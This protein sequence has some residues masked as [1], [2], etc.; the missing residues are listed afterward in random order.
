MRRAK[1]L[2]ISGL[3]AVAVGVVPVMAAEP[4]HGNPPE[5]AAV[6]QERLVPIA[7]C[8]LLDTRTEPA[9]TSAEEVSRTLKMSEAHCSQIIPKYAAGYA[10]RVITLRRGGPEEGPLEV[11]V[12]PSARIARQVSDLLQFP[13]PAGSHLAVDIEGY[14]VPPGI[15]IDAADGAATS[16]VGVT[17]Q[18]VLQPKP[19]DISADKSKGDLFLD[20]SPPFTATG[21]RLEGH[22][23]NPY[24]VLRP[25]SNGAVSF[26]KSGAPAV[27][28]MNFTDGGAMLLADNTFMGGR[29][30][31]GGQTDKRVP[32]NKVH[33]ITLVDPLDQNGS[34]TNRVVLYN[35]NITEENIA[36]GTTTPGPPTTK[37]Q[38]FTLGNYSSQANINFD[39]QV[40]YH[41]GQY[42]YRA[43]SDVESKETFWVKASPSA[44]GSTYSG[45]RATMYVSGPAGFGT[46]NAP[47]DAI[48]VRAPSPGVRVEEDSQPGSVALLGDNNVDGPYL[49]SHTGTDG[50]ATIG[51]SAHRIRFGAGVLVMED[52][53]AVSAGTQRTF[54]PRLQLDSGGRVVIGNPTVDPNA[55]LNVEGN[56]TISGNINAKYQDL[57]EWV[58]A[59]EPMPVGTVVVIDSTAVNGVAPSGRAYDTAVAGVISAQP[60][61]IL[62]TEAASK[63]KV[64]TT[65]R[66]KVRVSA[67]NG[68]IHA[69]DLLV[70]SGRPGTAMRSEPIDV[71]GVEIHRPGTLIGKALEPLS[72]GEGEILVLLS[73]Q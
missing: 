7:P 28:L 45:T 26:Y 6:A 67:S 57:A 29:Y 59:S 17:G 40:H 22:D 2:A 3:V 10:V 58:A 66:V 60:G 15:P 48:H 24:T 8:R 25:G 61:I 11:A 18:A 4:P 53:P 50:K 13:V 19:S 72:S 68:S 27:L 14:Y 5:A 34:A 55:N 12:A 63:V 43:Y 30:A 20:A 47:L 70:T 69:G 31:Y 73:L 49:V 64:A 52:A 56:V 65:G 46:A 44:A 9:K 38:A 35:A 62:G 39:S 21:A 16:T 42:Y 37:F 71:S 41:T 1:G 33:D 54:T 51:A 32:F 23:T 36:V